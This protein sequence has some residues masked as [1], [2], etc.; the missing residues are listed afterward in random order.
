MMNEQL[1]NRIR[2]NCDI[3]ENMQLLYENNLPLIKLYIK[4]YTAYEDM[5]D[6]LQEAYFGLL[7][8]TKHY[9]TSKNVLFMSYASYWIKQAVQRYIENCGSTVRIPSH[10]KQLMVRYKKTVQELEQKLS[11]TPTDKEIADTM[12]VCAELLPEL[13]IQMQGVTSLDTPFT[14]D[15]SLS[16]CDMVQADYNLENDVIEKI[17]AEQSQ[18]ELWGI[19]AHFTADKE[20]EIIKDYFAR[21]KTLSQ[22]AKEQ[23]V[24]LEYVRTIR[25]KGLQKL[26][27]GRA[28]KELL[29]KFEIIE[30]SI[31]RTGKT[32]YDSHNF[33]SK[34]EYIAICRAEYEQ[35]LKQIDMG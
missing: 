27:T 18:N 4:P 20:N 1:V 25:N 21:S 14:D 24:T 19:V 3:T 17:Y 26:R 35:E 28:R 13:K 33:T 23:G 16:L 32:N 9:E 12:R 15:D 8:A 10:R 22:I 34:V 6:L 30:A 7:E 11:R 31:Y 29:K 2:N 5:E